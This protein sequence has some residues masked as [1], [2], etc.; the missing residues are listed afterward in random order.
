VLE[1]LPSEN[2]F[3]TLFRWSNLQS[4]KASLRE[5][6]LEQNEELEET[7]RF[8]QS[9][10]VKDKL[11]DLIEIPFRS[12]ASLHKH[13]RYRSRYSDG[14]FPVLYTALEEGTAEAEARHWFPT[15]MGNPSTSRTGHYLSFSCRFDGATKDL[16]PKYSEWNELTKDN[17]DFCNKLGKE[18]L[19]E[20]LDALLSPSA[21][22]VDGTT[23]PV[24]TRNSVDTPQVLRAVALTLDPD[25]GEVF[26][27]V[28]DSRDS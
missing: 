11:D 21:R 23:V 25:T 17:Y 9:R 28:E 10:G 7:I 19:E 12:K 1:A 8:L 4:I 3:L 26:L 6:G 13:G 15:V 20:G 27:S 22:K 18:A 5:Q 16:R 2:C 14:S 24:F